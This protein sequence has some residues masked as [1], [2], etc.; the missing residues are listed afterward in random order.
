[1]DD[2]LLVESCISGEPQA[3]SLLYQ[4]CHDSLI[5]TIRLMIGKS[6]ADLDL[7][8]E[9]A[10]RVWYALVRNDG[11]LLA[12]FDPLRGCR[13]TT[14]LAILAKSEARQ[15]FRG[16]RRRRAREEA[17]SRCAPEHHSDDTWLRLDTE[18]QFMETLTPAESEY[19]RTV[20]IGEGDGLV[21]PKYSNGNSWQLRHR[22]RTKMLRFLD[23]EY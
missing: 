20:L 8:D 3:W 6:S 22:V 12:R 16:E 18:E 17:A 2:R 23:T 7:V 14:F 4:H 11:E 19:Y 9:I 1:M 15:Y 13:L 21:G 10:A 5:K